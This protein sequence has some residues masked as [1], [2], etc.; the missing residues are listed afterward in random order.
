MFRMLID[1]AMVDGTRH[2]DVIDPSDETVAAQVPDAT[3]AD[4][5]KAVAAAKKAWPAWRD[6]APD[7]RGAVLT[8]MSQAIA[9]NIDELAA[10]LVQETGR[11]LGL[12]HFELG[13]ARQYFDYYAA[14]RLTPE[15]IA[16]DATR[17][18]ELHRKPLGV[19]AAIVPWN[20]PVYIAA[21]KIAPALCAGNTIV[22]KTAPT[23]PLATLKLAELIA[24]LAPAGVVNILSGGNDAGA[25]LVSH[26]D[27]A[28]V[29]FT[30]STGTG[31]RIMRNA[32]ESIK[33]VSLELGG[34]SAA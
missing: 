10:L 11:P 31:R 30:G 13:L 25:A 32:A 24:G 34:K 33:R 12:A 29:T 19:V 2:L 26:D 21:N 22:V 16:D 14:Q 28:K 3:T 1:G 7:T 8:A 4:V 9:D 6:T 23:T 15:V 18:V 17:R 27:V 5:D 20:A